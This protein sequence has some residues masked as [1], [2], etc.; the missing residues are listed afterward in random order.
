MWFSQHRKF[1]DLQKKDGHLHKKPNLNHTDYAYREAVNRLKCMLTDS[2][3]AIKQRPGYELDDGDSI[4]VILFCTLLAR[5][6]CFKTL[7]FFLN[8]NKGY[9]ATTPVRSFEMRSIN[10]IIALLSKRIKIN[11]INY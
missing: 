7:I 11:R 3:S 5:S 9:R 6:N 8:K 2:Y 4:S 10:W 1:A